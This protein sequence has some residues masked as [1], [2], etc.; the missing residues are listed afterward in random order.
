MV[1]SFL[2]FVYLQIFECMI[3]LI[4]LG[5]LQIQVTFVKPML[6][7]KIINDVFVLFILPIALAKLCLHGLSK[8]VHATNCYHCVLQGFRTIMIHAQLFEREG[9]LTLIFRRNTLHMLIFVLANYGRYAKQ[10]N[11]THNVM[12][13]E[14][15]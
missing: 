13:T 1:K 15:R 3:D 5:R 9:C 8:C 6:S 7:T 12:F 4:L 2:Y 11:V 10:L 14:E